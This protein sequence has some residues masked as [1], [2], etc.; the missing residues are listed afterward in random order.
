VP[1]KELGYTDRFEVILRARGAPMHLQELATAI[2][3]DS[4]EE[5]HLD[6]HLTTNLL[7]PSPRFV[8]VGRSGYWA[9]REWQDVETRT[10]PD[11]AAELLE[12]SPRPLRG[13]ELY[14]LIG[15]RRRIGY[16]SIGTLLGCDKRFK[17]IARGTWALKKKRA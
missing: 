17:K 3:A 16:N 2:A 5:K 4:S 13:I 8:P 12:S 11:M 1:L 10:I 6:L 15:V 7:S 9:L 14:R